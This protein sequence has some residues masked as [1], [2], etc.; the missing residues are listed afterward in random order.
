MIALQITPEIDDAPWTDLQERKHHQGML[1]RI[2][3]LSKGTQAGKPSVM[4]LVE[5]EDGTVVTAQTTLALLLS[6][7]EAFKI[8]HGDPRT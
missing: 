5:C 1:T 3:G 6:A 4:I 2:A 7:T 8:R